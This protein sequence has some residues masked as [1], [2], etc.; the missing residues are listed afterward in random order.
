MRAELTPGTS[1][2]LG[3]LEIWVHSG[4]GVEKPGVN[5]L[6]GVLGIGR[7]VV[8]EHPGDDVVDYGV[9]EVRKVTDV[10]DETAVGVKEAVPLVV[11]ADG[12]Y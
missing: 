8:G 12:P 1:V 9:G 5:E 2:H 11:G 10:V 4:P 3:I 6:D 7:C